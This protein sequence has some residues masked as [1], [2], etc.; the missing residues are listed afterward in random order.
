MDEKA[1][2]AITDQLGEIEAHTKEARSLAADGLPKADAEERFKKLAADAVEANEAA[3]IAREDIMTRQDSI[4]TELEKIKLG[5]IGNTDADAL[6]ERTA[7][8]KAFAGYVRQGADSRVLREYLE[9]RDLNE[10]VGPEGGYLVGEDIEAEIIKNVV[11]MSP[12]WELARATILSGNADRLRLRKRADGVTAYWV[13]E[14]AEPTKSASTY[15]TQEII[16]DR[17]AVETV[18]SID[19]L[20]DVNY[21]ENEMTLDAS[22]ALESLTGTA[23]TTGDGNGKPFG[24]MTHA[25]VDAV[26]GEDAGSDVI[27]WQDGYKLLY[28]TGA[29]GKGL[30]TPYRANATF[31]FNSNV[32][33]SI[34]QLEDTNGDPVWAVAPGGG[35][36]AIVWGRPWITL[37][38]MA[39]EANAANPILC[40]DFFKG[41][42]IVRKPGM[43]ILRD[44]YTA[45]PDVEILWR[46]RIGG[47][48]NKGEAFKKLVI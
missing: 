20:D 48:V 29:A 38:D 32:L 25:D 28:G 8:A 44:P 15:E 34:M 27:A 2:K 7:R 18:A 4:L 45:K 21:M 31:A 47:S 39:D 13:G 41:Y 9:K 35:A 33:S 36:V 37:E 26:T 16:A 19:L 17:C 10:T 11:N 14:S 42:R 1:I 12:V 24:L 22:E 40:G 23:F 3:R 43:Y 30:K 6:A 46:L 5:G